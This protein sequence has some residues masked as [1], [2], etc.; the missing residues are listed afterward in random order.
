MSIQ[1][2]EGGNVIGVGTDIIDVQRIEESMSKYKDKFLARVYTEAE[3]KYCMGMSNPYP[4]LAARFAAKEAV[5]KAFTTGISKELGWTS[6]ETVKGERGE[7]L[8]K[9][10]EKGTQLL[11]EVGGKNVLLSISHTRTLAQ[12]VAVIIS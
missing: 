12:A 7:P 10:D 2:P 11:R 6:I 4:H 5:S 9:L 1:L 3:Q 8:V